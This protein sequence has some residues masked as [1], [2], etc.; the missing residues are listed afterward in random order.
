VGSG[1]ILE[2]GKVRALDVKKGD[3]CQ[4]NPLRHLRT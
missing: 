3:G 4:G 1:R 2:D